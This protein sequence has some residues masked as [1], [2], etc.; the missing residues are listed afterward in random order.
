MLLLAD[1]SA[2]VGEY[3]VSAVLAG[4]TLLVLGAE[5][6]VRGAV[7]IALAVG[8]SRMAVGLTLVSIGTSLPELLVTLTFTID[9]DCFVLGGG[10]SHVPGLAVFEALL[11][12][13][14]DPG[15]TVEVEGGLSKVYI[16]ITVVFLLL[17]YYDR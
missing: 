11:A 3:P 14:A 12:A 17:C 8:M 6:L 13:G 15:A 4:L 7:W 10:I 9:P 5:V 16:Y 2:W 1:S